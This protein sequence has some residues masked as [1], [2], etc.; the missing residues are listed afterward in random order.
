V[1]K[2]DLTEADIRTKFITPALVASGW[3]L[4]TQ[5]REEAYFTKGRVIV[6]GKT[7]ARGEANKADYLLF[8]KP[9]LPIA[10]IEAK[11][12]NHTVA[13]GMGQA[14]EYA[15]VLDVPFG[16]RCLRWKGAPPSARISGSI[17]LETGRQRG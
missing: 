16:H 8:Y 15:E 4:M 12:N 13:S 9:N 3:D 10:V 5:L 7:V 6:R 1:N 11:D 2:K 14:L 17:C